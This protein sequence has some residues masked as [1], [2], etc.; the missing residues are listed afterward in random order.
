MGSHIDPQPQS[1]ADSIN[2]ATR[3][4]HTTLNKLIVARLPEALPP[5]AADPSPYISGLL[6]IA[7][8]YIQFEALW[9]SIL[10]T[11]APLAPTG[12]IPDACDPTFPTLDD[13]SI[14]TPSKNDIKVHRPLTCER[15]H[16]VLEHLQLPGLMRSSQLRA[17]LHSLT[18]WSNRDVEDELSKIR[19]MGAL[20]DFLD[21]M[22]RS[23]E[24]KPHVLVAYAYIFYMALFAGGRFIRAS[25]EYAG[26]S[27]W[28]S[29]PSPIKPTMRT[30]GPAP[31]MEGDQLT[32]DGEEDTTSDSGS[33]HKSHKGYKFPLR[34]LHFSTPADGE[35]LK[36]E[37]KE[38][39]T[40]TEAILTSRERIDIIQE[41]IAIFDHMTLLVGHLH[42][43][44]AGPAEA[45][46]NSSLFSLPKSLI[47]ARLRDSV[48]VA[49]D[50]R[51]A[52]RMPDDGTASSE[53][54]HGYTQG[55][56]KPPHAKS[57][58][59]GNSQS[60]FRTPANAHIA[61]K[62]VRFEGALSYPDRKQPSAYDG[63]ADTVELA[64]H[65][66]ARSLKAKSI[67][68]V[69]VMI[70]GLVLLTARVCWRR[71]VFGV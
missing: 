8:V 67:R 39:L 43:L 31:S 2:A 15:L 54:G 69:L 57:S 61:P 51:S 27:F 7:P 66:S 29:Q 41:A 24:D 3:K 53:G 64:G 26:S 44:C 40:Q 37:F 48:A 28:T 25:L 42:V 22:K 50:R 68:W 11:P 1:L 19:E 20:R 62:S 49:K 32:G 60:F 14:L 55:G 17:D 65:P 6:H 45:A 18:R 47:L 58:S 34:F 4:A 56:N 70:I 35:D 23:V 33:S 12:S 63:S 21:H 13:G 5:Q 71:G 9:Q 38:R 10:D 46:A 30:C 36:K 52:R 16:S 59:E